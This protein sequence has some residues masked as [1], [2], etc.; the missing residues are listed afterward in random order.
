MQAQ[1]DYASENGEFW[2]QA[3]ELIN[4][5]FSSDGSLNQA[6]QLWDLLKADQGWNGL[7]KFGQL[8]W[9]EEISKAIIAASQ[10]YANWNMYKA[11]QVDKSLVLPD[12]TQLTYDGTNWKDS[13]G[14]VYK[15]VDFNSNKNQFEYGSID[16]VKPTPTPETGGS[17]SSSEPEK[18][19]ISIGSS[20]NASGAPIYSYPGSSAQRQYFANDPYYVAIGEM[21]DYWM[22][23]WHGA[24]S[25]VTGF[26]KKSDVRA[27]KTGGLA[28]FTGPAWLDGSKTKPE[29]VLSA[30][31]TEN[32]LLLK[33]V[34]GSFL[35]NNTTTQN[36][37]G[38]DNYYDIDISVDEIGS[39]YD[40]DQLAR[41]IKEQITEDSTYRNVNAINF[42][43]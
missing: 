17:G 37:K 10:G 8:N 9:Q 28:D 12:G 42:I 11:E 1:L 29:L 32:F 41:R 43:R 34:L 2:N 20:F 21:G 18:K 3:Y 27:Y 22:A 24:S 7:S 16:Y 19:E 40:V 26:F 38:G 5:G 33:D 23:R 36:G 14:N 35:K 30:S 13:Q 6:S 15:G 39:D 4:D 31:D 25:G